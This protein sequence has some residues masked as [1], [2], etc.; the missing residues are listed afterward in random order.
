MPKKQHIGYVCLSVE[1]YIYNYECYITK[2]SKKT[3]VIK[4]PCFRIRL[5]SPYDVAI[6]AKA[7]KDLIQSDIINKLG[8]E[9]DI[10]FTFDKGLIGY[11]ESEI[12]KIWNNTE[13]LMFNIIYKANFQK[14]YWEVE[15]LT[16][17]MPVI[18]T[19]MRAS[20]KSVST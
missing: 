6:E 15:F 4:L 3:M 8:G 18:P 16:R 11:A 13:T 2:D 5:Q 20:K 17:D 9:M 10:K 14:G 1:D 12:R 7:A 19:D